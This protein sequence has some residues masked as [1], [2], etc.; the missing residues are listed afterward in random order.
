[1]E[2]INNTFIPENEIPRSRRDAGRKAFLQTFRNLFT[3]WN[4]FRKFMDA[5][6]FNTIRWSASNLHEPHGEN[7]SDCSS[8]RG[9]RLPSSGMST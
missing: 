8:R 3:N 9:I 1:M 6:R 4:P 2:L 7:G 5:Y